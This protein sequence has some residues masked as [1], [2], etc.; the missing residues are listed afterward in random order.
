MIYIGRKAEVEKTVAVEETRL[1]S[2]FLANMSHEIRSPMNAIIGM[3][4]LVLDSQVNQIQQRHLKVVLSSARALLSLINDI[5]DLSKLESG[6]MEME[7]VVFSP[8]AMLEDVVQ[9]LSF[10]AK[11]KGLDIV[12]EVDENIAA[13][14]IGDPLRL[15]QVVLNLA[16]NAVK[17]TETGYIKVQVVRSNEDPEYLHFSIIDTGIGIAPE[18]Q[19]AIFE[20][21]TQ[22]EGSTSRKHGG[23]G[24]GTTI[25]KQIIENMNGRIWLESELGK[26]STFH[27]QVKLA[28][29]EG[30][31]SCEIEYAGSADVINNDRSLA[32]LLADDIEE[33]IELARIRLE[34]RQHRVTAAFNGVE[35]LQKFKDGNFDVILMDVQ[36]PEM[37]GF[38]ATIKIREYETQKNQKPIPIIAMTANAMKGDREKCLAAG[39]NDYASKPID[40]NTLFKILNKVVAA[41][42]G[43]PIENS[44]AETIDVHEEQSWAVEGMPNLYGIDLPAAIS[45]WG[46]QEVYN[47]SLASFARKHSQGI[48]KIKQFIEN[49]DYTEAKLIS[50]A[51]KGVAANLYMPGLASQMSEIDEALATGKPVSP[52]I[53]ATAEL[54]LAGIVRDIELKILNIQVED[55]NLIIPENN[56]D[57]LVFIEAPEDEKGVLQELL[58]KIGTASG[59]G[60]VGEAETWLDQLELEY[61][62]ILPARFISDV[63]IKLDDFEFEA[64]QQ[65]VKA[66]CD[67]NNID[68]N[69]ADCVD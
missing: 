40:F 61:G 2:Q 13:C 28:A 26:G 29:A 58:W 48:V 54:E 67:A 6:K 49:R 21:F 59:A 7:Q 12:S 44:E 39:M 55:G 51:L 63:K 41:D 52:E 8:R 18:R 19:G 65:L 35:V 27:F 69:N 34:Q 68:L 22:A 17:F 15:R 9:T 64:A 5:L 56:N 14:L 10:Q 50:H 1:K 60:S 47:K 25:S 31:E 43:L 53:L 62:D 38:D 45:V 46:N 57:A 20:S 42:A 37:D 33:N 66:L 16:G 30:I 4:E 36:M 24:L 3:T 23:T 11:N 32:V